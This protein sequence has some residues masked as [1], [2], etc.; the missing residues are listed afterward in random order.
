VIRYTNFALGLALLLPLT[1]CPSDDGTADEVGTT[2]GT[3]AGDT[4]DETTGDGDDNV[5]A[6]QCTADADCMVDG[7]DFGLTC[8]DSFCASSSAS[9]TGN[10]EC[11]AQFSGWTMPCTAGGGECDALGQVCVTDGVCATPPSDFFTCDTV[12]GWTEI[13]TT[14]IDGA[15]VTVCGNPNAECHGEGYCFVPC[16]ADAD[17]TLAAYPVCDTGTGTCKC[18]S[19]A[20]CATNGEPSQSVCTADGFCGCS[21][22]QACVDAGSG[23]V[24][25]GSGFCGCSGDAACAGVNNTYDGGMISCVMI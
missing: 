1:G 5:C 17:C 7:Q 15:P 22:D 20:D 16:Q 12:P 14:D 11:V 21:D 4:G 3:T 6:H 10:P 9:C 13:E 18:G 19:D 8:Q 2:A 24:C 23:D 25:T